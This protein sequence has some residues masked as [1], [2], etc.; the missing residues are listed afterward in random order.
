LPARWDEASTVAFAQFALG[1]AHACGLDAGGQAWCIGNNGYGQLGD[2]GTASSRAPLAVSGGRRYV[3]IV[4]GPSHSCALATDGQ[5]WCWGHGNAVG[6]GLG[7]AAPPRR[8]PVAVTGGLRFVRLTAGAGRTCGLAADG[9][10]SC[11]GDGWNGVLGDGTTEHRAAPVAV[12]V[13]ALA[14]LGAGGVVT[15]G[16]DTTGVAWCWGFN[17]SGAV[18][19]PVVAH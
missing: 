6:D 9:G 4:A 10:A 14:A 12:A 18:G 7:D 15:C 13:P 16:I 5:A 17:E 2:G 11:W 8:V 1:E 3:E 19:R